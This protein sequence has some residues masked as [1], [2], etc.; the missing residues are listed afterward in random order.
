MLGFPA[1]LYDSLHTALVKTRLTTAPSNTSE[2][3]ASKDE[4]CCQNTFPN[5]SDSVS[6]EIGVNPEVK[7]MVLESQ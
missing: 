6:S 2:I 1:C 5:K 4:P 7:G 3:C